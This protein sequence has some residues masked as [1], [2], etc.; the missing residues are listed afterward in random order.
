MKKGNVLKIVV[1]VLINCVLFSCGPGSNNNTNTAQQDS[2][3]EDS[4]DKVALLKPIKLDTAICFINRFKGESNYLIPSGWLFETG[5][6]NMIDNISNL[7]GIKFYAAIN[8][9]SPI[10][11][12]TLTL[13]MIPVINNST[14][15]R[16]DYIDET[17]FY[18][19]SDMCP[20]RCSANP[21]IDGNF[22]SKDKSFTVG[23]SWYF[24]KQKFVDILDSDADV[25]GVRL[26]HHINGKNLDLKMVPVV[27]DGTN[28]N[29]KATPIY[30]QADEI[31]NGGTNCDVN[32]VLYKAL[33]CK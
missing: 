27:F 8:K 19:F 21:A 29:D 24:S 9:N 14:G 2:L 18:E 12:D 20:P 5:I 16:E 26:Y 28:Y 13:V 10:N 11:E 7:K 32:S 17:Y 25:V 3:R 6:K 30:N 33:Q 23:R 1:L 22:I 31:C 4:M 15:A